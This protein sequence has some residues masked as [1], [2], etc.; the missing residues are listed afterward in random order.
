MEINKYT[1]IKSINK[2]GCYY[3]KGTQIFFDNGGI[4]HELMCVATDNI[5]AKQIMTA[6]NVVDKI[7]QDTESEE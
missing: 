3:K 2:N 4:N 6:L 5:N 1:K 7:R